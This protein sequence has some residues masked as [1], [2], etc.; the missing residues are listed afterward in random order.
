MRLSHILSGASAPHG[1]LARG[2]VAA[3]AL[4]VVPVGGLQ[5]VACAPGAGT[6]RSA[7]GPVAEA[8]SSSGVIRTIDVEGNRTIAEETVLSLLTVAP[9]EGFDPVAI[10][11]SLR[12]MFAS[13]L[14]SDV[15][16]E[17]RGDVL[18]VRVVEATG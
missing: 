12:A 9:G 16:F 18:V 4:L 10:D 13:G 3:A 5:L 11:A 1:A 17:R 2:A 6:Q 8:P 15:A 7:S 14:F